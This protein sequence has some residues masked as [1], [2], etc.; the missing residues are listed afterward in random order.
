M[1]IAGSSEVMNH[2]QEA[3]QYCPVHHHATTQCPFCSVQC[4]AEVTIESREDVSKSTTRVFQYV[5]ES[6][7]TLNKASEGRICVKGMNAHQH[8]TSA[9]RI[10]SP[11]IKKDG[12]L[13]E[14]TWEEAIQYIAGK[15]TVAAKQ[16][17]R[18]IRRRITDQ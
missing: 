8:T 13:T 16:C 2:N 14:A 4:K 6:K 15:I 18:R 9:R 12:E 3:A 1:K 7:G 17:C 5:T 11:L 10:T